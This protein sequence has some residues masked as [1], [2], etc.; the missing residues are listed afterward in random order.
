MTTK[1]T[2]T[3]RDGYLIDVENNDVYLK[4]RFDIN[5]KL[6]EAMCQFGEYRDYSD[7]MYQYDIDLED[8]QM[9]EEAPYYGTFLFCFKNMTKTEVLDRFGL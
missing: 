2:S 8:G 3:T 5:S 9:E 6:F 4:G 7:T 1:T